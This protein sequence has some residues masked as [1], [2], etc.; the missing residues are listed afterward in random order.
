MYNFGFIPELKLYIKYHDVAQCNRE[1]T[2]HNLNKI[3]TCNFLLC[4]TNANIYFAEKFEVL[5]A[6]FKFI[7]F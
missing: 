5:A 2:A 1:K 7:A 3:L 6:P 4:L